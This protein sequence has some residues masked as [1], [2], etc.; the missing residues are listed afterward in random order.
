[1]ASFAAAAAASLASTAIG[2]VGAIQQGQAQ[3]A[4][5]TYNAAVQN[6]NAKISEANAQIVSQAGAEQEAMQERKTRSEVGQIKANQ[7]ASGVDVNSGS[8]LDT[9]ASASELGALDALTIRSNATKE[10]YGYQVQ[11]V[12]QKAQASLDT[13]EGQNDETAS[14]Y[15]AAGTFLGGA[16]D[17]SSNFAKYRMAGGI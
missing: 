3:K 9:Q 7:A 11:G 6:Q 16:S 10:A 4:S 15:K 14:Y 2:T 1:M 12:N 5:A 8:A 13:F 17:A